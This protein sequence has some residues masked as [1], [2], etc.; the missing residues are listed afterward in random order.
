M[1]ILSNAFADVFMEQRIF[2]REFPEVFIT[3]SNGREYNLK[4]L[5]YQKP[6]ILT[7]IFTRC[8]SI[9]PALILSLK[10]ALENS[11]EKGKYITFILSFAPDDKLEDIKDYKNSLGFSDKEDIIFGI[12][13]SSGKD[14]FLKTIGFDYKKIE[15]TTQ[16]DHPAIIYALYKGRIMRILYGSNFG[17]KEL[18]MMVRNALGEWEISYTL[19]DPKIPYRCYGYNFSTGNFE[20]DIG[21]W[22]MYLPWFFGFFLTLVFT[23]HRSLIKRR[24]RYVCGS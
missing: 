14:F 10:N 17:S 8:G 19:P 4:E 5:S 11:K 21:F 18:D 7:I 23:I 6:L 9:C 22:L 24:T 16:Y 3:S 20:I 15:G 13:N 2:Y 1:L 12:I